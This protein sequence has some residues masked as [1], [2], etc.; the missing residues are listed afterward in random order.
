MKLSLF[1]GGIHTLIAP[2]LIETNE[3]VQYT[4]LDHDK[5]HLAPLKD[6][7]PFTNFTQPIDNF[8]FYDWIHDETYFTT[9]PFDWVLY[10][11]VLY[12]ADRTGVPERRISSYTFVPLGIDAPS[13]S[14]DLIVTPQ[15]DVEDSAYA[16]ST[17]WRIKVN[18][19]VSGANRTVI[20]ELNFQESLGVREEPTSITV[21]SKDATK[22]NVNDENS[23]TYW[24]SDPPSLPQTV[25]YEFADPKAIASVRLTPIPSNADKVPFTSIDYSGTFTGDPTYSILERDPGFEGSLND[26]TIVPLVDNDIAK[27]TFGGSGSY[28]VLGKFHFPFQLRP[29]S[30]KIYYIEP[31]PSYGNTIPDKVEVR[32]SIGLGWMYAETRSFSGGGPWPTIDTSL[33]GDVRELDLAFEPAE[34][35]W[36]FDIVFQSRISSQQF[37][38]TEVECFSKEYENLLKSMAPRDFEIQ[39]FNGTDWITEIEITGQT[40]WDVNEHL[41]FEV[42][43]TLELRTVS[44]A[45][46]FY[47]STDG[48][49][50]QPI[51][52]DE[53]IVGD[54][55]VEVSNIPVSGDSQV[56]QVRIYR[57]GGDIENYTLVDTIS[58][59]TTTYLDQKTDEEIADNPQLESQNNAQAPAGLKYLIEAYAMLFGA[60]GDKLRFTPIGQPASWP[61]LNFLDMPN[62]ITAIAKVSMGLLVFTKTK[63]ILVTG[64]GPESLAQQDLS[65]SVGCIN[66]DSIVELNGEAI[67]VAEEGVYTSSGD[68]PIAV[69]KP[70]LG[71][72]N[73]ELLNAVYHDEKYYLQLVPDIY[74]PNSTV[75]FNVSRAEA[76]DTVTLIITVRDYN[77]NPYTELEEDDFIYNI[78]GSNVDV[79]DFRK[80][81][82]GVYEQDFSSCNVGDLCVI[83][84]A[85]GISLGNDCVAYIRYGKLFAWGSN[86]EAV[87]GSNKT[88]TEYPVPKPVEHQNSFFSLLT[89]SSLASN[90]TGSSTLLQRSNL[91]GIT[92]EGRVVGIGYNWRG[93]LALGDDY[94]QDNTITSF[95]ENT[96]GGTNWKK[97]VGGGYVDASSD[98]FTLALKSNGE[99][100]AAGFNEDGQFGIGT[101]STVNSEFVQIPGVWSDV[102][103]GTRSVL[104]IDENGEAFVWGGNQ[105]GQLGIGSHL[106]NQLS[107]VS[108]G[109][110][111]TWAAFGAR[112]DRMS[113]I[114]RNGKLYTAGIQNDGW[115]GYQLGFD[116]ADGGIA[117][118]TGTIYDEFV[119]TGLAECR[120][121]YI[122]SY[123]ESNNDPAHTIVLM[124]D[125]TIYGF[126]FNHVGQLGLG[127]TD[128]VTFPTLLSSDTDWLQVA[129]SADGTFLLKGNGEL[130]WSGNFPAVTGSAVDTFHRAPF[131]DWVQIEGSGNIVMF[132][133]RDFDPILGQNSFDISD[134]SSLSTLEALFSGNQP[135]D[136]KWI[137]DYTQFAFTD[138]NGVYVANVT[139]PGDITSYDGG[140][141][142]SSYLGGNSPKVSFS[143]D[144]SIMIYGRSDDVIETHM[145]SVRNDVSSQI[146]MSS[147]SYIG[148]EGYHSIDANGKHFLVKYVINIINETYAYRQHTLEVPW[149][150]G[151]NNVNPTNPYNEEVLADSP[152]VAL[153]FGE[154]PDSTTAQDETL[155]DN[156]ATYSGTSTLG[157]TGLIVN[158]DTTCVDL[159]GTG[160]I[161]GLVDTGG[162]TE[163]L[164]EAV[165]GAITG[166]G[167][168]RIYDWQDSSGFF[169]LRANSPST[170]S[171]E[172]LMQCG[173]ANI[174][175]SA[176]IDFSKAHDI[177]VRNISESKIELWVDNVLVASNTTSSAFSGTGIDRAVGRARNSNANFLNAKISAFSV[178]TT[179]I[180]NARIGIHAASAGYATATIGMTYSVAALPGGSGNDIGQVAWAPNGEKLYWL[181][182]DTGLLRS[183]TMTNSFNINSASD[184]GASLGLTSAVNATGLDINLDADRLYL[185]GLGEVEQFSEA[186]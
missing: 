168:Q 46:T 8:G 42:Q 135:I 158:D 101:T 76:C 98:N 82:A 118:A 142:R 88:V 108:I 120:E 154:A 165:V 65:E 128:N 112:D 47:N 41:D 72:Q 12:R 25:E 119:D 152:I 53:V 127:H 181:S 132:G 34:K 131:D 95:V 85:R 50:S 56:D 84:L 163:V 15:G 45:V 145:L 69:T 109:F 71:L 11:E 160:Y 78:T 167:E 153:R 97:I 162:V 161:T 104:A 54:V 150:V 130:Y 35:I 75:A 67:W 106:N 83:A 52:S 59:G 100:Y 73:Y 28:N 139:I 151:R 175:C 77:N 107:P 147:A 92:Q 90:G 36:N 49:E 19:T 140:G 7:V 68:L 149:D 113:A 26:G 18:A 123:S 185:C 178:Y 86:R 51:F 103:A 105:V 134:T 111:I 43:E 170:G 27:Y 176:A 174:T 14:G 179:D 74:P 116:T 114:I 143:S 17:R 32:A 80:L 91:L 20:S 122:S 87:F 3:G 102:F 1:N 157:E 94:L 30:V 129:L 79:G 66:H 2:H 81:S 171:L 169:I 60:L 173:G 172:A 126:G 38:L 156:D 63:T 58:N 136:F 40:E 155:N 24:I 13:I 115:S 22:A 183:S 141:I 23:D 6:T 61:E 121:V 166:T 117:V 124:N 31:A 186:L 29:S 148:S 138:T 44:Y 144:G 10:K 93:A 159:D 164:F 39:Y 37:L 110:G 177:F 125:G 48:L 55:D 182:K 99:L 16:S 57:I 70:K 21:S 62:D 9:T 96:L 89:T 184:D 137:N 146:L 4:N 33:Y 5:G 180:T 64:S 133:L